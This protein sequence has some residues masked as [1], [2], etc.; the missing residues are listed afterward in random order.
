MSTV[1]RSQSIDAECNWAETLLQLHTALCGAGDA[2]RAGDLERAR[3]ELDAMQE[4]IILCRF[5]LALDMDRRKAL[6]EGRK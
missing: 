2:A 5:R 4:I 1:R 6:E 3:T